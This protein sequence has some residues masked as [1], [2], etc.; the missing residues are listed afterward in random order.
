MES[1]DVGVDLETPSDQVTQF[2][3]WPEIMQHVNDV[4]QRDDTTLKFPG[5][6]WGLRRSLEAEIVEQIPFERIVWRGN[7]ETETVVVATFHRLS[8]NLTRVQ[9]S[10]NFQ[11]QGL[12]EKT[13]GTR[14]ARRA[15]RSDLLH[16]K[17]YMEMRD[18]AT[19]SWRGTIE[20]GEVSETPEDAEESQGEDGEGQEPEASEEEEPES[21][22]EEEEPE[23]SSDEEEEPEASSDEDGEPEASSEDEGEEEPP[24]PP[25][26]R[27]AKAASGTKA[28]AGSGAKA[29]AGSGSG[30][31]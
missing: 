31:P 28:K 5:G 13:T 23:A 4:E 26:R 27:R 19:G 14:L 8:Y 16:F 9:I 29:K 2:G 21:S 7:D 11:P 22:D 12:L 25:R 6:L 20:E 24:V 15:L 30:S 10:M 18:E 3:D 17:A 1:V